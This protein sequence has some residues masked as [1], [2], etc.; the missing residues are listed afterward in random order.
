MFVQVIQGRVSD[1]EAAKGALDEW[2]RDVSPG[3]EGW[4][5]STGGVTEDGRLIALVRFESAELARRNSDRPEQDAWWAGFSKLLT[6]E[7]AFADSEDVIVDLAGDPRRGRLRPGH[8][9]R[10]DQYRACARAHVAG[11]RQM[12]RVLARHPGASVTTLHPD[13]AYTMC[14][15]LHE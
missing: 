11:L 10:R 14:M 9:W 6:G 4:L 15:Y 12:G 5:G 2:L 13:G 8:A 3:A 7:G 1:P